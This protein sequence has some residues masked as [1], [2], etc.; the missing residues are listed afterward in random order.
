MAR[1]R[2]WT[3]TRRRSG[4]LASISNGVYVVR[5][6]AP[7]AEQVLSCRTLHVLPVRSIEVK[8]HPL[9]ADRVDIVRRV[10]PHAEQRGGRQGSAWPSTQFRRS[11]G[12][13]HSGPRP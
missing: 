5:R 2:L 3:T 11:E 6:T 9:H 4:C 13:R 7:N 8:D 10:A 12:S 1:S